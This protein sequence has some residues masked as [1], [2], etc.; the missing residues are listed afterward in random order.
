MCHDRAV[1][2]CRAAECADLLLRNYNNP[3]ERIDARLMKDREQ[4]ASEN[5]HIL[6]QM[7]LAIEFLAKQGLPFRGHR[8]D[9][10]DFS[11]EDVNRGNFIATLQIVAK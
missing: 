9:K 3:S 10:V 8:D 4:Q 6:R 2:H 7:I 11:V 1:M 5:K